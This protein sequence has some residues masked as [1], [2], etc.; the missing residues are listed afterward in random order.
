MT[1]ISQFIIFFVLFF[2]CTTGYKFNAFCDTTLNDELYILSKRAKKGSPIDEYLYGRT[3]ILGNFPKAK[4]IEGIRYLKKAAI[5]GYTPA[6]L[7]LAEMY[8]KGL[9]GIKQDYIEAY[10]WYE[11]GKEM[12]IKVAKIKLKPLEE[13]AKEKNGFRLFGIVLKKTDRFSLRYTLQK[14]GAIPIVLD[15]NSY[16]D[17]FASYKI[18]PG[19]DRL[20]ACY[21]LSGRFILLEYR[22]PPKPMEYEKILASMLSKLKKKYGNPKEIRSNNLIDQYF[23]EKNGIYIYFWMEPKTNT[24]FLRYVEPKGYQKLYNFLKE[25]NSTKQI[26]KVDFF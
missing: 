1:N 22:Y 9:G 3:L 14:H 8:E 2:N 16:C 23:W 4:K 7:F 6:I 21:G 10:K 11:K 5:Q 17:I 24:C 13:S 26:P 18:I 25:Q 19:S 12:G 15:D 20:Q